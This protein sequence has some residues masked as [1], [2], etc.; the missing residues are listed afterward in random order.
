[1]RE[2]VKYLVTVFNVSI[3]RAIPWEMS[4]GWIRGKAKKKGKH[5]KVNWRKQT[6]NNFLEYSWHT[7]CHLNQHSVP[8]MVSEV[9][10]SHCKKEKDERNQRNGSDYCDWQYQ[11]YKSS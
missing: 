11:I 2:W 8:K 7:C 1:M 5:Q 4:D 3:Y 6:N 9:E 10:H